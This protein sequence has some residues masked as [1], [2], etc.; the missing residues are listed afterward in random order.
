MRFELGNLKDKTLARSLPVKLG[1]SEFL[2]RPSLFQA[3]AIPLQVEKF[4]M[5]CVDGAKYHP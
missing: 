5:L 3:I 2:T 4:A 1:Q